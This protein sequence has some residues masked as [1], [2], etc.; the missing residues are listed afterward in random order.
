MVQVG[1]LTV[2][3][4]GATV[5][6]AALTRYTSGNGVMMTFEVTTQLGTVASNLTVSYVGNVNATPTTPSAALTTSAIV[7]RLQP[8]SGGPFTLLQSGDFGVK[9]VTTATTSASMTGGALALNLYFPLAFIP[10]VAASIY[11]ERDS[12]IQIDGLSELTNVSGTVGCLTLYVFA[13]GAS[14]G[15][16]VGFVRAT[17]G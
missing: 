16:L 8:T 17:Q 2:A 14:T 10:G 13:N 9:S 1:S 15:L 12:T 11:V 5:N 7:G 4:T 6:S 3:G